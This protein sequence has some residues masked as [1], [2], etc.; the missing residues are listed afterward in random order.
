M[1]VA[2]AFTATYDATPAGVWSAPGR[3]NLIG[4][5]TDYNDGFVLPFAIEARTTVAAAHRDD[6]MVRLR[7]VQQPGG[8][9]SALLSDLRPGRPGGWAAYP[10][11]V[12]WAARQSGHEVGGLDVLVD[13]R[14][15]LGSGLSSSHALECAVA[16]AVSDLFGLGLDTTGLAHLTQRAENDFVGAPTGLMDQLASLRCTQG[17]A[18]FLD[19]RTLGSEQVPLDPGSESLR[20]LVADTRVHH[21]HGD[22][23]YGDRRAACERA[24]KE[25]GVASLRDVPSDGLEEALRDLDDE[26]RRRARHVVTENAR[27]VAA[28]AALRSRDWG[29]LGA[30]MGAS[31]ASLRDD[32]EVSCDELDVAVTAA[33][34]AGAVG[35]RMT[36]GGFGGS[37]VVLAPESRVRAV[38]D[39]VTRAF[40]ARGWAE[41]SVTEVTPSAGARRDA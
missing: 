32:Y 9:V 15:P 14:V 5:H 22:G 31:H 33:S 38:R 16:M 23:S 29:A 35:A 34:D 8:D 6:G 25:L 30:L 21:S 19:T 3:V 10:A 4:E 28:V 27:V 13:G 2:D 36:G 26:L 41:P 17:H 7:S 39:A 24:A 1:T 11:G 40:A 20:L 12:L 18:L 37:A